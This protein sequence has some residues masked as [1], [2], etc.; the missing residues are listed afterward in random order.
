MEKEVTGSF[1]PDRI[2]ETVGVLRSGG[3][4]VLPT[5]TIYG[6]HCIASNAAAV[7]KI[8]GIKQR[9]DKSGLILLAYDISM[10]DGIVSEWPDD[11]RKRL[12]DIWP[13][14]LTAILPAGK[15]I[16]P[17]LSPEGK[18]AVRIPDHKELRRVIELLGEA[19]V[20]TSVNRSGNRP[21]TKMK[22]IRKSFGG[23]DLYLSKRGRGFSLPSTIVD[24]SRVPPVVIREGR[25]RGWDSP[26]GRKS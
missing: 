15:G 20:S 4:A 5:D 17:L 16:L 23:L 13:A 25:C 3:I 6:M 21:L 8:I 26:K 12:H 10:L 1:G 7:K 24:C 14:P 18:V 19:V 9:R 22:D 2:S 11:Y